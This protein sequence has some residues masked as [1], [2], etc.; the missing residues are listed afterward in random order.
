[1]RFSLRWLAA[2]AALSATLGLAAPARA[3]DWPLTAP[4]HIVV[5]IMENHAASQIV[6]SDQAPYI[7]RLALQSAS[8]AHA[9]AITHP[10]QPNYL[11]L[12]A[13]STHGVADNTCP[14]RL[15]AGNLAQQLLDA[16]KTFVGYSE[17]LP[18]AGSTLCAAAGGYVRKHAPWVSF[19][20]LAGRINQPFSSFPAADFDRLP[21][22]AFV[23]PGLGHDMHDGTVA[24]GDAWLEAHI[25]PYQ[26]WAT[27]H[28]SL[29]ILTWDED[30]GQHGNQILTLFSGPM[31]RP[32]EYRAQ[33]THFDVLR[34]IEDLLG[35]PY[36]GEAASATTIRDIW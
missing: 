29:L 5:V 8:F 12:F 13:G 32:G 31:V 10:S 24:E 3:A 11:A 30:D 4:A 23:V 20:A 26:Q 28:N 2:S 35:L 15:E 9:R 19:E 36:V 6:A 33:I 34:T 14:L 18:A 17:G 25:R 27:K 16:G 21:T 22:V 1:M 7:N